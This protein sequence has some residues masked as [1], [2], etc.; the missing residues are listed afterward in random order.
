MSKK[1]EEKIDSSSLL[2]QYIHKVA[3]STT[4]MNGGK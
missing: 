1:L 2:D 4:V 3:T